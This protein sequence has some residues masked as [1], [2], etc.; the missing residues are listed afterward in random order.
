MSMTMQAVRRDAAEAGTV[1]HLSAGGW[2][3][4]HRLDCPDA[5]HRRDAGVRHVIYGPWR[6][7]AAHWQPCPRCRP[8][9]P[10]LDSAA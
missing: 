6:Y 5:P 7:M 2:T 10:D 3:R 9:A 8:P 4:Y 1:A